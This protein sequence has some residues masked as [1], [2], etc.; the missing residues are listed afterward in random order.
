LGFDGTDRVVIGPSSVLDVG[1]SN[2]DFKVVFW[3][4]RQGDSTGQWKAILHKGDLNTERTFG[5]WFHDNKI[6]Y[7]ISVTT[8][9]DAGGESSASIPSGQWVEVTYAKIGNKLSLYLDGTLDSDVTLGADTVSNTGVLSIGRDIASGCASGE[10]LIDD[11]RIYA[12]AIALQGEALSGLSCRYTYGL[13]LISQTRLEGGTPE[14]W[15]YGYD[16]HGSV[17]YLADESGAVTDTYTYD[18]FGIQIAQSGSATPN[19]YRY[20]G[21]QWDQ[22]LGMYYLRARYFNPQIGRFW[23]MDTFEGNQN[24]PLS[25]HKYLY[26]H[27]DPA[28]GCD[29]SG[30]MEMGSMLVTSAIIGATAGGVLGGINSGY[31]GA[32]KGIIGGAVLGPLTALGVTYAGAGISGGLYAM[33]GKAIVTP[34]LASFIVG[35]GL[36][37]W[38]IESVDNHLDEIDLSAPTA[39][40][41][42]LAAQV[43]LVFMFAGQSASAVPLARSAS[44][45]QAQAAQLRGIYK[46]GARQIAALADSL[47]KKGTPLQRI[48]EILSEERHKN[49]LAVRGKMSE[50]LDVAA[51]KARDLFTYGNPDGPTFDWLVA[52]A[53]AKGLSGDDVWKYIIGSSSRTHAA[54]DQRLLGNQQ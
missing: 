54:T 16:G 28:N 11:L 31:K 49:R 9:S 1:S 20:T 23:T 8:N 21:E 24:D 33:F 27:G 2:A 39:E 17:R 47:A 14:T 53:R 37:A 40:R 42:I 25:L 26:C 22:D 32:I 48:A 50:W 38:G 46:D 4:N 41:E 45:T 15:Y 34:Q 35:S 5:I 30:H 7:R 44:A 13:D 29:P 12:G 3:L 52:R 43:E 51:L 10:F 36:T 18:A 6:Y 19:N